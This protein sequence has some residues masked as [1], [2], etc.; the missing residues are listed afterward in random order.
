[1]NYLCRAKEHG[2]DENHLF[3][4][5]PHINIIIFD[6]DYHIVRVRS[7]NIDLPSNWL[8]KYH[9]YFT[10]FIFTYNIYVLL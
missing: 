9:S 4:F 8:R 7:I 5:L 10:S 6:Y 2:V 3:R 1:M